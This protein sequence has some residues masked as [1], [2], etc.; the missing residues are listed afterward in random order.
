MLPARGFQEPWAFSYGFMLKCASLWQFFLPFS[1]Y[2]CAFAIQSLRGFR[3][4]TATE[5][6]NFLDI[7]EIVRLK[8]GLPAARPRLG[9]LGASRAL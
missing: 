7:P 4:M 6:A 1:A 8:A 5:T 3:A 2:H 9:D